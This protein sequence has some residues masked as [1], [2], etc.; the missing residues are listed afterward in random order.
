[1]S[2]FIIFKSMWISKRQHQQV[3][4]TSYNQML[5]NLIHAYERH[6]PSTLWAND[7]DS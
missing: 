6:D 3:T 4:S 1:M 5:V 7:F 2:L